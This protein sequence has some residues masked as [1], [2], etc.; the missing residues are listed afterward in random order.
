MKKTQSKNCLQGD[1]LENLFLQENFIGN[2]NKRQLFNKYE[3]IKTHLH[4]ILFIGIIWICVM[5]R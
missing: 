5:L 3:N 4:I 1:S 2:K